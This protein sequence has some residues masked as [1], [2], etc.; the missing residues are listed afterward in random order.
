MAMDFLSQEM[1][2]ACQDSSES[3]GSWC[4]LCSQCL[5]GSLAEEWGGGQEMQEWWLAGGCL[6]S[7]LSQYAKAILSPA[8]TVRRGV[9][10]ELKKESERQAEVSKEGPKV[11]DL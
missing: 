3:Q 4:P 1:R 10:R 9:V 7:P 2:D 11:S 5:E 8:V 6:S